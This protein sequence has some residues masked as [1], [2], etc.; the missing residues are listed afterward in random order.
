MGYFDRRDFSAG[1]QP[2]ADSINAPANAFL[3][4]DNCV[5]DT[6]GNDR[7]TINFPSY[8][9]LNRAWYVQFTY[10]IL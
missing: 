10:K 1:W 2:D 7:A 4:A 9:T 8:A 3:R 5:I 6:H